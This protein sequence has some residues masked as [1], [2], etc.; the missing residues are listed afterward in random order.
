MQCITKVLKSGSRQRKRRLRRRYCNRKWGPAAHRSKANREA[1]LVER[2]VC[3][4]L[5]ASNW[6]GEIDLCPKADSLPAPRQSGGKSFYRQREGLHAERA[7]S[8]L[9]VFLKLVISGLTSVILIVLSTVT[10][11]FQGRFV[12]ISL[13]PILG[14]VADYIMAT[15]W[16][17]CS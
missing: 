6:G 11:Q 15:V 7:Q 4:I 8:A 16:Y 12:R 9:T 5:D 14:I 3:F 2:K 10:P 17:S 1:R 13:R